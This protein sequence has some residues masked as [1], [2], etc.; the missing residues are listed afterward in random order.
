V[1][2][3]QKDVVMSD[4]RAESYGYCER[5]TR[6]EAGN[7]YH[8]FRFLPRQQRLSMCALYAF[9]RVA[10]DL[11]DG[12]DAAEQ[13]RLALNDWADGFAEALRGQF[14]HPL[15]AALNDTVQRYAI[16]PVYLLG[17]IDGVRMDLEP[18]RY[19]TFAEL[20]NYCYH[21]ASVVGLS[22]IHVWG[23][24][25]ERAKQLAEESGVAFQL[26]NILRDLR[27]DAERGRVYLPEEDLQRFGYTVEELHRGERNASFRELMRFQVERA[28]AHYDR[29]WPLDGLL[30][31]AG[32]AVFRVMTGTYRGL[33][34]E[35]ARRDF[36]VFTSRVRLSRW[37]KLWLAMKALPVRY[38]WL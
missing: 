32:R 38:G 13:K 14:R 16:P 10:D 15:H 7:F 9:M 8:A 17:V 18:V 31:P 2:Q 3:T 26:T 34:E 33:L 1:A 29:S 28:R 6:R 37:H 36:D 22:C 27:E 4:G 11:S 24:T 23:F 20:R 25:D 35:I 12:L 30:K 19:A 5:L 21:V